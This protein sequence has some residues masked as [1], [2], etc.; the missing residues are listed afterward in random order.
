MGL[1]QRLGPVAAGL[2]LFVVG[3]CRAVAMMGYEGPPPCES[4]NCFIEAISSCEA[5][6]NYMTRMEVGA[7]SQYVVEGADDGGNCKLAMIYMQ[8]PES[9]WTYKPVHFVIDP[10]AGIEAQFK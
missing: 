2:V 4:Q 3:S 5:D 7:L 9:E 8:H 6:A 1:T 10:D